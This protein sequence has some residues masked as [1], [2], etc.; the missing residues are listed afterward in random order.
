MV[1]LSHL[2][3]NIELTDFVIMKSIL[4][5]MNILVTMRAILNKSRGGFIIT[6]F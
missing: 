5:M 6:G 1:S 3:S 4:C 2:V